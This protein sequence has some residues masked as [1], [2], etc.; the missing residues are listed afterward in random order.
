MTHVT[1]TCKCRL[2]TVAMAVWFCLQTAASCKQSD[3]NKIATESWVR[4]MSP[5]LSAELTQA[6]SPSTP[7]HSRS[8]SLLHPFR[9]P[10]GQPRQL[11]RQLYPQVMG[12]S[13]YCPQTHWPEGSGKAFWQ[14]P[15]HTTHHSQGPPGGKPTPSCYQMGSAQHHWGLLENFRENS[16]WESTNGAAR[17]YLTILTITLHF[18]IHRQKPSW[19]WAA[20]QNTK[21]SGHRVSP[22]YQKH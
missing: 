3:G 16:Y 11:T 10:T 4:S 20:E 14:Q 17:V 21:P 15:V 13:R 12:Q 19:L 7:D 22:D 5:I 18:S 9:I 2:R 8:H 1:D 6:S